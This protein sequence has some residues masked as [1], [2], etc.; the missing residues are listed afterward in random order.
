MPIAIQVQRAGGTPALL[1]FGSVGWRLGDG[2][3]FLEA[4]PVV[5][6][7]EGAGLHAIDVEGA[8]E[9]IDFVL[10][11]AGVPAGGLDELWFGAFVEIF[12]ADGAGAGNEGGKT[13]E[14]E[15]AFV[16]IP[17]FVAGVGDDGIDDDVKRNGAALAF[18]EVVGAEA[19]QQ[20][21]AVFD[22]GE[23][24]GEAD[25]RSGQ[26]DAGSVAHGFAHFA[27]EALYFFA[28]DFLRREEPGRL[29][30]NG[31]AC[32]HNLQAHRVSLMWRNVTNAAVG[33]AA[34]EILPQIV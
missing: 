1:F 22:D 31:F 25:L 18:G 15:A 29:A 33:E 23:L 9:M 27:N 3:A 14:A 32:L 19:F 6:G 5:Q 7:G 28:D 20:I 26:A 24:Q 34:A 16:E 30:Q 2:F 13:G 12:D 11:D 4:G 17:F 10:E 21:F 8:V